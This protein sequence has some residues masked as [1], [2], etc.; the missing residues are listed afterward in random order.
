MKIVYFPFT[1]VSDNTFDALNS[2][3]QPIHVLLPSM[4][5]IPATM[6]QKEQSGLLVLDRSAA[7]DD[8]MMGEVLQHYRTWAQVHQG[9]EMAW[10]KS[11][12]DQVPFYDDTNISHIRSELIGGDQ[13]TPE[14]DPLQYARIF[15]Q[16][17]LKYDTESSELETDLERVEQLEDEIFQDLRGEPLSARRA[18]ATAGLPDDSGAFMTTDR[19]NAWARLFLADTS[20]SGEGPIVLVTTSRAVLEEVM[21]R[22]PHGD[23]IALM[24]RVS[25]AFTPGGTDHRWQEALEDYLLQLS[26]PGPPGTLDPPVP[27]DGG[28]NVL[29]LSVYRISGMS[30]PAMVESWTSPGSA[31]LPA[32]PKEPSLLALIETRSS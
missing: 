15:L 28:E 30:V 19:L 12:K 25:V 22:V 32:T 11:L 1:F 24:D 16:M 8:A 4:L 26:T 27:P 20:A 7:G 29:S 3:F 31:T 14:R 13:A 21:D 5:E 6:I 9:S 17:A 18:S 10:M 23:P 2:C